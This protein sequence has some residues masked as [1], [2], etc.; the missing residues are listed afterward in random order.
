MAKDRQETYNAESTL[1]MICLI[2]HLNDKNES[3]ISQ[4]EM[5]MKRC[6]KKRVLVR[7]SRLTFDVGTWRDFLR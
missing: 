1:L 2:F 4:K 3:I 6:V 5:R 7:S